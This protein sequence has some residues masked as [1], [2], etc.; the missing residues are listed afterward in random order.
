M[1][2]T[3]FA[4]PCLSNQ[5]AEA[6]SLIK[7][8]ALMLILVVLSLLPTQAQKS[9]ASFHTIST[10]FGPEDMV[11]DSLHSPQRL[12][13]SCASRRPEYPP[14]G[15]IEAIDPATGSRTILRRTGEPAGIRLNPHGI[16]LV[17]AGEIQYL[18]VISHDDAHGCHPVIRYQVD[19]DTLSF[20]EELNSKLLISPN[21]VQAF[22][23]GSLLVCNDAGIRNNRKE[24]IFRQKRGNILYY[25]GHGNWSIV[26]KEIGM[27]AGL[28]GMGNRIF[29]SATLENRLYSYRLHNGQ[30][31]EK[32]VVCSI[33]SPDNIRIH[34]NQLIVTSHSKTMKFIGH[35]R[36][37]HHVSPSLVLS[38]DPAT[39]NK[40]RL[41][42]NNGKSISAASVAVLS[43]GQLFIGQIF[44]PFIGVQILF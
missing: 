25:D 9:S 13:V 43:N 40:T 15:E 31:T 41:F 35:A 21:A 37:M 8:T 5:Y 36:N 16:S 23:D 28:A 22:P 4:H 27:P 11:M 6:V 32:K 20:V 34:Q 19:G 10:G 44:E 17:E 14:Y 39:G 30:L 2:N 33:K 24:Q 29:V 18:Y 12:L 1:N 42:Y 26:E 38:V 7:L 3:S